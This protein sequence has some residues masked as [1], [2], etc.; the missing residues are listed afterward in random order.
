MRAASIAVLVLFSAGCAERRVEAP[1]MPE[2]RTVETA[3]RAAITGVGST[4][5]GQPG[6]LGVAVASG[7]DGAVSVIDVAAGSPAAKA[8]VKAGDVLLE[9]D[10]QTI[11]D[12]EDLRE[13]LLASTPGTAAQILIER[14]GTEL[15]L[16]AEIGAVSR[17]LALA[18]QRAIL[19][20]QLGTSTDGRGAPISRITKDSPAEKAGLKVK[21]L[22]LA[23]DEQPVNTLLQLTDYLA[24]KNPG[25]AVTLVV[26]RA[27]KPEAIR[28]ILMADPAAEP[29]LPSYWKK[30]LYRLAVIGVEYPDTKHNPKVAL[31]DWEEQFFST[32]TY[33]DRRSATGQPVFGSLNDYYREQS[34]GAFRIEGKVFE[35]VEV[36]KKRT[37][38]A[39]GTGSKAQDAFFTEVVTKLEARDGKDALE[40][41]DGILF[42]YAGTW[43]QTN[44]GGL[45]WPHRGTTTIVRKRWPFIIVPE[46]GPRMTNI[47]VVAHEFGHILGLPDLYARPE[48]PGSTGL[49]GWSLMSN[50]VSNGRPQHMDPWCKEQLGWLKPAVIDPRVPQRLVLSPVEGS[51]TECFKVLVRPDG[52]EYFLLENRKKHKFDRDLAAEGLFIWRVVKRHPSLVVSH[53]VDGPV[54]PGVFLRSVPFPSASNDAFTPYTTPSSRAQLGGGWP[55]SITNIRKLEDGR[56]EFL[57]GVEYE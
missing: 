31:K 51:A 53:G 35:W 16:S 11:A 49:G 3:I 5:A 56:T 57:I 18:A 6:Y 32:G 34:C 52:S 37:D 28:A 8:G 14:D 23:V 15:T 48:N 54:G 7:D 4:E 2:L 25:D 29:R 19:G 33:A 30:D 12:G 26:E 10:G 46:G 9:L 36:E 45:Y 20:I 22:L 24:T 47:S 43:L 44:R 39:P 40:S 1:A 38:Y 21:D 50:Q 55:V 41:F 13:R 17:P 42:I 27:G